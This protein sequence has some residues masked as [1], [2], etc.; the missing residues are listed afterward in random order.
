[1]EREDVDALVFDLCDDI[2]LAY[3]AVWG[4]PILGEEAEIL[5]FRT[6]ITS[7][8]MDWKEGQKELLE[9]RK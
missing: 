5:K 1:M 9:F 6:K 8:Y 4:R 2:A 7:Q 3:K